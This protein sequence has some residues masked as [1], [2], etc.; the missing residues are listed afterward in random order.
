MAYIAQQRRHSAA[1]RKLMDT[2]NKAGKPFLFRFID[3]SSR[4]LLELTNTTDQ[5]L[6]SVEILTVFLND[7]D[8]LE[9]IG[10]QAHIKFDPIESMKPKEKAV[11]SH[12]TWTNGRP[13]LIDKLEKLKIIP[14][15]KSPY[16]LDISWEDSD[17]KMRFQR[18][19]VG[20]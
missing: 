17:G 16:V 11:L 4:I 19:P 9:G 7:E 1:S 12:K 6:K 13:A 5:R 2:D 15:E 18:I 14:G 8:T 20:H 3:T 10:S